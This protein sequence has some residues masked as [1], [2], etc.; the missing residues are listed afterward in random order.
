MS[1]FEQM[2]PQWRRALKEQKDLLIEIENQVASLEITPEYRKVLAAYS[3]PLDDIKV[4]IFGQDPYPTTG[5]AQGYA[6]A[7]NKNSSKIPPT[8]RNIFKELQDDVGDSVIAPG[9]LTRWSDQGVFLLNR[10]LTTTPGRSLAHEKIGWQEFTDATAKVLGDRGVVALLWGNKTNDLKKYFDEGHILTAPH[11]SP[12]SA[13]RGFFGSKPFSA[14]N[15]L[16][17]AQGKKPVVW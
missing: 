2:H 4:V 7:I 9:N 14:I 6:F 5:V 16:L 10:I 8:L 3:R 13:Y 1:F 11:P 17:I 15:S 12:L